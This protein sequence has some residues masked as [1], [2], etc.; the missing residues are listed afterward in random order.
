[1]L[2]S[3]N[4]T[5][6]S[7]NANGVQEL[8]KN[9]YKN[10]INED[11]EDFSSFF[12]QFC[13]DINIQ[14]SRN[15]TNEKISID[16]EP[17]FY[18]YKIIF[19]PKIDYYSKSKNRVI[20]YYYLNQ[21][22]EQIETYKFQFTKNK[23]FL[24]DYKNVD[25]VKEESNKSV[26]SFLYFM[27]TN[28]TYMKNH[29]SEKMI[30]ISIYPNYPKIKPITEQSIISKNENEFSP[31]CFQLFSSEDLLNNHH[32]RIVRPGEGC[33]HSYFFRFKDNSWILVKERLECGC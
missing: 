13:S 17:E 29:L 14:K 6:N 7:S 2:V 11:E 5:K 28:K 19:D 12:N 9:L 15:K 24:V 26:L 16:F 23:W 3:W 31:N 21:K 27:Q 22:K 8:H 18:A 4:I 33:L 32:F 25:I 1:V 10:T 30:Y 20:Y